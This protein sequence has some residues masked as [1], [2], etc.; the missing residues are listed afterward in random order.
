MHTV[1]AE[2]FAFFKQRATET[3]ENDIECIDELLRESLV[4]LNQFPD[5]APV[6]S[7]SGHKGTKKEG[8]VSFACTDP[9][10]VYAIYST[11][12]DFCEN[13]E[14]PFLKHYGHYWRMSCIR[15]NPIEDMGWVNLIVIG[16]P[17][18]HDTKL[19]C[20]LFE[21]AVKGNLSRFK[22]ETDSLP[23]LSRME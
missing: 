15:R 8:Y 13:T 18:N 7:C 11:I 21:A 23:S 5:I 9:F 6:W 16:F 12:A 2:Q 17:P 4:L 1:N 19:T 22:G 14:I 20:Q 10:A 3:I